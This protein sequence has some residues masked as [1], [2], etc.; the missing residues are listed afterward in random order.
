MSTE[1][2]VPYIKKLADEVANG[3][4]GSGATG[5]QAN[6]RDS[7]FEGMLPSSIEQMYLAR[8]AFVQTSQSAFNT[9]LLLYT[10]GAALLFFLLTASQP[11]GVVQVLSAAI[12][13]TV[14][15]VA[16]WCLSKQWRQK[17][18][19][20]YD[21]YA[22]A[23]IHATII[24]Y[25]LGLPLSHHW[26]EL[27]ERCADEKGRFSDD[28]KS[29]SFQEDGLMAGPHLDRAERII[30]VW[31]AREGSLWM[32]YDRLFRRITLIVAIVSTVL[33][34]GATLAAIRFPEAIYPDRSR[35]GADA[36]SGQEQPEPVGPVNGSQPIRVETNRTS[37][38]ADSGG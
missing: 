31:R 34:F 36:R 2:K 7:C 10:A 17:L 27:V 37:S 18:D 24:S 38:A 29:F 8:E 20:G 35:H 16:P 22:S 3:M 12:L 26:L 21:L 9:M 19:A 30:A 23:A 25:A 15:F 33:C 32:F 13:A 28:F 11:P 14:C 1:S 4:A 5:N 6:T